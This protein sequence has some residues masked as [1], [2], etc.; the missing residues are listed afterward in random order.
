MMES[1]KCLMCDNFLTI[2]QLGRKFNYCSQT[3]RRKIYQRITYRRDI[4]TI[5]KSKNDTLRGYTVATI[6]DAG[7]IVT[8]KEKEIGDLPE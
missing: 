5:L 6:E 7:F 8:I 3:C 4:L 2:D 1:T